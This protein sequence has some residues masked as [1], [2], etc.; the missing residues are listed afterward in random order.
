MLKLLVAILVAWLTLGAAGALM[1]DRERIITAAD[2]LL[3]P[4]TLGR[5]LRKADPD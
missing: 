1:I 2:V 5:E 4:I 3:G